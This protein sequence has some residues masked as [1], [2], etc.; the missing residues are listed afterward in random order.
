MSDWNRMAKNGR[1]S[2]QQEPDI[3]YIPKKISPYKP[4]DLCLDQLLRSVSAGMSPT[5][6]ETAHKHDIL[7]R[8]CNKSY[9]YTAR[10]LTLLCMSST[11][12]QLWWARISCKVKPHYKNIYRLIFIGTCSAFEVLLTQLF[13]PADKP[14]AEANSQTNH[15]TTFVTMLYLLIGVSATVVCKM[16]HTSII[17]KRYLML[18]SCLSLIFHQ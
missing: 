1:I 10:N 8:S 15:M 3:L 4:F 6:S 18:I 11:T 16:L 7:E 14:S 17:S 2:G 12:S 9:S 13:T 5:L